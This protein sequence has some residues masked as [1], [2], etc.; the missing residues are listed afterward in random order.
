M[1]QWLCPCVGLC[2]L[3]LILIAA[4]LPVGCTPPDPAPR[5]ALR[6]PEA[7]TAAAGQRRTSI[8][9]ASGATVLLEDSMWTGGSAHGPAVLAGTRSVIWLAND[10]AISATFAIEGRPFGEA[11]LLLTAL[12]S[13]GGRTPFMIRINDVAIAPAP[14][15]LAGS[16][17]AL[18]GPGWYTAEWHVPAR[19]L[20]T[21]INRMT[22]VRSAGDDDAAF[23][24]DVLELSYETQTE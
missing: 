13:A 10:S 4:W 12:D 24:L 23:G 22:L 8:G 19:L 21:G 18:P 2:R 9:S 14:L 16:A 1:H 17:H 20:R 7:T 5:A 3:V 6:E 15:R 11:R